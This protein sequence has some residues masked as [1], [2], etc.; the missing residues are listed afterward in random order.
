MFAA[1]KGT[2]PSI[3]KKLNEPFR[4]DMDDPEFIQ[5][6]EKLEIEVGYRNSEYL[7]KYLEEAYVRL[8]KMI[9]ELKLPKEPE[10]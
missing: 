3:I 8:G 9:R 6:M 2:P 5:T 10:K 7:K 1:P 4:K